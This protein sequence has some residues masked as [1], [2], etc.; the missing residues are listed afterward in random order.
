MH[1]GVGQGCGAVGVSGAGSFVWD[2]V[3]ARKYVRFDL[4]PTKRKCTAAQE[5]PFVSIIEM[6]DVAQPTRLAR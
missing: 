4:N 5:P 1:I 2:A 6:A 3:E